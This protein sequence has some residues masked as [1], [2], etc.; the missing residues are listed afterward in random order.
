MGL[1]L[2]HRLGHERL[3]LYDASMAEWARDGA[4]PIERG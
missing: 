4:L 3:A 2:L 1:F